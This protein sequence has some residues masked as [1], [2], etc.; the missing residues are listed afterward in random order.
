MHILIIDTA[1]PR[2]ALTLIK[3][4]SVFRAPFGDRYN[5]SRDVPR[6]LQR[7]LKKAHLKLEAING[8]AVVTGPGSFTSIRVG[9]SFANAL[10]YG[11]GIPVVGISLFMWATAGKKAKG[12]VVVDCGPSGVFVQ[13]GSAIMRYRQEE[14]A[15]QNKLPRPQE[16][17]DAVLAGQASRLIAAATRRTR[18][19]FVPVVPFYGSKPNITTPK[20]SRKKR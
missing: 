15:E 20:K 13:R 14:F 4:G 18:A 9:V 5:Q 7:L 16:L 2:A 11:Q 17:E 3:N 12:T 8:I 19:G 6:L 10:A 1:T